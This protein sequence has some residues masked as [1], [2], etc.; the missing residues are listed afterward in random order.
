MHKQ[1]TDRA[2]GAQRKSIE[3]QLRVVDQ[4]ETTT[5]DATT[6]VPE[7]KKRRYFEGKSIE[8][9]VDE[10]LH[11]NVATGDFLETGWGEKQ[12]KIPA[13]FV[14]ILVGFLI[15][16]AVIVYQVIDKDQEMVIDQTPIKELA[17]EEAVAR[18]LIASIESTVRG[19]LAAATIE[20]KARFVRHPGV[21]KLRMESFYQNTPLEPS[22]CDLVTKLRPLTLGG[23]PFWQAL[24]IID[25]TR[26]E[27]LLL[28]QISDTEVL[29]DWE[30]HVD[31][32]PMPWQAYTEKPVSVPMSF[33]VIVEES[34]RYF[35]EFMDESRWVSYRLTNPGTEAMIY[36]YVLR[37][38]PLHQAIL[39]A[40]AKGFKRMILNL[41]GSPEI[42]A[43][44]SVVIQGLVSENIYRLQAPTTL[45][46]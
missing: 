5:A 7:E 41:K 31:Y 35:D 42:K 14:A 17:T 8:Y 33:R 22:P 12:G 9:T 23:R 43:P 25:Q 10:L 36:G 45:T 30:S 24:A 11:K 6:I 46:D 39:S 13:G 2:V 21:T 34:P 19:Y 16:V 32:Q 27:G 15:C 1:R 26:G 4:V 40:Q 38:S 20:E 29:I 44:Q 18:Q 37:N 28:E 3:P